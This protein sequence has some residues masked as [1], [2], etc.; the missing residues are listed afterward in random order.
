MPELALLLRPGGAGVL[1]GIRV[2]EAEGVRNAARSRGLKVTRT[3]ERGGWVA[4]EVRKGS[5]A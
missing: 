5:L 4:L 3:R 1:S 2:E